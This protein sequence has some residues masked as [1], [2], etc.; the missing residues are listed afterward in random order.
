MSEK[1]YGF[2]YCCWLT[3]KNSQPMPMPMPMSMPVSLIGDG[4]VISFNILSPISVSNGVGV[5]KEKI[6]RRL[7]ETEVLYDVS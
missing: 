7:L 4:V 3:L 6:E 5:G 1:Y 2:L